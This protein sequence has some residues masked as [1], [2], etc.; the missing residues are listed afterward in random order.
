MVNILLSIPNI[1]FNSFIN[2]AVNW[3]PLSNIILLGRL[4][5]F[6]TL[7]L[8]NF[9]NPFTDVLSVVGIKYTIFVSWSTI[10]RIE[11]YP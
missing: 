5:S 8:N 4:Y 11:L 1:L 2:P 6:H 10:T 9:T 3:G 7:S